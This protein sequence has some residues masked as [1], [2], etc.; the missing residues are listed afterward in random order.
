MATTGLGSRQQH[1]YQRRGFVGDVTSL[2][3]LPHAQSTTTTSTP[4]AGLLV[5]LG[6]QLLC[7]ALQ[8]RN[9]NEAPRSGAAPGVDGSQHPSLLLVKTV[10]PSRVHGVEVSRT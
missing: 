9:E 1:T 2:R 3:L 6:P 7:Y 5:G 8:S 10:L 4:S